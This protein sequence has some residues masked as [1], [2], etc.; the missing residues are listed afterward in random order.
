MPPDPPRRLVLRTAG[1]ALHT[2]M[3]H[4]YLTAMNFLMAM[5]FQIWPIK[6][7]FDWPFCQSNNFSLYCTLLSDLYSIYTIL[8]P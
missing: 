2:R 7:T 8:L 4:L 5:Q 3:L 6:F 1:C